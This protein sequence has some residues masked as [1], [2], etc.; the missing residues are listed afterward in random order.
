MASI[1]NPAPSTPYEVCDVE[2]WDGTSASPTTFTDLDASGTIGANPALLYLEVYRGANDCGWFMARR[3]GDTNTLE[4]QISAKD[5]LEPSTSNKSYN[6]IMQA[7]SNGV[8]EW[9]TQAAVT[10]VVVKLR[11]YRK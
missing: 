3:N 10:G 8:F 7:D 1:S 6:F 4:G 5:I 11:G 2:L 9:K